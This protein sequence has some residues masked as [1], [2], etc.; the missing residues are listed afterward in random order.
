MEMKTWISWML[1]TASEQYL[2]R[3][4]LSEVFQ[5]TAQ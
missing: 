5:G 4:Q 3:G 1:D 2:E